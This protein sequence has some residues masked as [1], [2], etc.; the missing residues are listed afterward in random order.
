MQK[1][2]TFRKRIVSKQ[3]GCV[4]DFAT[5]VAH[6]PLT[7][8]FNISL[9][10]CLRMLLPTVLWQSGHGMEWNENFSMEYGRYQNGME[11]K[12]IFHTSIPIPN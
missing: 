12:S 1:Q 9:L 6:Q 4:K 3:T 8:Q 5:L 11:W 7:S 2:Q 10:I